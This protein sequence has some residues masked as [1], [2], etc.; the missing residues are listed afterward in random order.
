M[1]PEL[2]AWCALVDPVLLHVSKE[3]HLAVRLEKGL[4]RW[5]LVW[6]D[7]GSVGSTIGCVGSRV[8]VEL[9]AMTNKTINTCTNEGFG[10]TK[11]PEEHTLGR[12]T[13]CSFHCKSLGM[14]LATE[15]L[16]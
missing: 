16:Q 8:R 9:A 2:P 15:A 12:S 13:E 4:D 10:S 11:D 7:G 6:R 14:L 5:A 3:I 1:R